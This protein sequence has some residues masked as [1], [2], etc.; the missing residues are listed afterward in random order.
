MERI[1]I[2]FDDGTKKEYPNG[3]TYY[4]VSKDYKLSNEILGVKVNNEIMPLTS[5]ITKDT[6]VD[7]F[8]FNDLAG[9]KMY[10]AGLKFIF[11]VALK[12]YNKNL[13]VTYLHSV[14]KGILAEIT[15]DYNITKEDLG[16]IKGIMANLITEDNRFYKFNVLKKEAYH[17]YENIGEVNKAKNI[18]SITSEIVTLYKLKDYINYFYVEL[19]YST[20]AISKFD[21]IYLGNN[22]VVFLFPSKRTNGNVPEYVHYPNIIDSFL[23]GKQWLEKMHMNFLPNLN[24][25]IATNK[26]KEFID[27]NELLFNESIADVAEEIYEH[28]DKRIVLIAGPSSSGKTTTTKRLSSYLKMKGLDPICIS[29]DDYFVDREKSPKD[30]FGNY[31]WE[32][33]M[34]IDLDYF[35]KQLMQL[36]NGEAVSTPE[37]NFITGK[38]EKT[39]KFIKLKEN[40]IILIEGLHCLNDDMTPGIDSKYK[41]KIYLSPFI[42]LNVD[43]HNYI[44]TVDLRMIRRI[45]RDNRTR[46]HGVDKTIES[47]QSVRNGEEK[48]IF[49]YI[50]QADVIIN[51][52]LAYELGVLKEYILPL[53]HSVKVDE[54]HYEEARRL[55]YFLDKFYPIPGEYVSKES[56]LREFIGGE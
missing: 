6:K 17:Y 36:L 22:R 45:I 37:F 32:C 12:T 46:G 15:G 44:S 39:N 13:D 28:P 49:P 14:P 25:A 55:I 5:K 16:K 30:E 8:D 33:L 3:I 10:Q 38:R 53:L 11:E 2:T 19:P 26:I 9:Y 52:A 41:Y 29:V 47:W 54:K 51:T 7:F 34:A 35:N 1:T 23:K 56:I 50:H 43:R 18:Q 20:K 21:V 42:P 24:D 31:D 27:A 48:Y 4:E 40:S